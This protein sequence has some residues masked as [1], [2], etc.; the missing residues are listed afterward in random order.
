MTTL[1]P[2][3]TPPPEPTLREGL[4]RIF[5]SRK[6]LSGVV[7]FIIDWGLLT[8]AVTLGLY[9]ATW[10]ADG[11]SVAYN[12]LIGNSPAAKDRTLFPWILSFAGWLVIPAVIGGFAGHLIDNRITG[13]KGY[14]S[15]RSV[16]IFGKRKLHQRLH[17]PVRIARLGNYFHG[18]PSDV[19][20]LEHFVRIAHKNDWKRA[21]DH[22]EVAVAQAMRTE[23]LGGLGRV[24]AVRQAQ[25]FCKATTGRNRNG[26]GNSPARGPRTRWPPRRNRFSAACAH[27]SAG[28]PAAAGTT[29]A[30]HDRPRPRDRLA[31]TPN[32]NPANPSTTHP[33]AAP[34]TASAVPRGNNA[35]PPAT[36]STANPQLAPAITSQRIIVVPPHRSVTPAPR[37]MRTG[38]RTHPGPVLN[39]PTTTPTRPTHHPHPH[40]PRAHP[41]TR[42]PG[43]WR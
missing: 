3:L 13:G 31:I 35:S 39:A 28:E 15:S 22:W 17:P 30:P 12:A 2:A 42:A 36:A 18:T 20:F 10:I 6:A 23:E 38:I 29:T 19:D 37:P 25:S 1:P 11:W 43:P 4:R 27:S 7:Q 16:F 24:E 9:V 5:R 34:S 14:A 40:T 26:N 33:T 32:R 41:P 21:Q 8:V